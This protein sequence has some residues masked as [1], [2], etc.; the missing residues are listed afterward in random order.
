VARRGEQLGHH[1]GHLG[2]AG[3]R[4]CAGG[5]ETAL[6]RF[7]KELLAAKLALALPPLRRDG[8]QRAFY[9]GGLYR[10]DA[11]VLEHRLGAVIPDVVVRRAN[12]D[13]IVEFFVTHA[14]DAAK[15][16]KIASLGTAAIEIDLSGLAQDAPR[17]EME[18]AILE[19][20]PRR[21]LHN[22]RLGRAVDIHGTVP[23]RIAPASPRSLT[24]L[25]RAYAAAYRE[26]LSMPSRSLARHRIEADGLAH[27]IGI[28]VAGLG[29]F[30]APPHDWQA[31]IL[32]NALERALVGG[33]AVVN[34][35]AA[36]KQIR[37]RGR[38]H[39]RFSRLLPAEAEALCSTHAAF[40]PPADAIAAW[41]M[42]LSRQ[43]ILVPSMG[44]TQWVIR[45]ETLQLVR[46]ARQA[47]NAQEGCG[48][49]TVH[50]A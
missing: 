35:K 26:A 5:P 33:P 44:R 32:L 28:E 17:A 6:H 15:V 19:R 30:T 23:T 14:C 29:C 9:A 41:A 46:K 16:A 31:L 27:T 20:A 45:R 1:F 13:L 43:G 11:A 8:E 18:A 24:A 36:L 50:L 2:A 42:A 49:G 25:Q 40:A 3:E 21:W 47:A 38:L 7:A 37:D 12:R 22:P 10:F 39:A 34:A 4:P 48:R